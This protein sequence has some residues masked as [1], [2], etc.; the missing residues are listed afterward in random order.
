MMQE[1][2]Q[3]V[4]GEVASEEEK[5]TFGELWQ[6]RVKKILIDFKDDEEVCKVVK[7]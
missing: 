1:L 2:M 6:E 5:K 3:K 4:L 7:V